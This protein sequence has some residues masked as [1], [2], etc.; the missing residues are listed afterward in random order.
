MAYA[1]FYV[2]Q[3]QFWPGL[4]LNGEVLPGNPPLPAQTVSAG[5]EQ[6][7]FGGLATVLPAI[8][9]GAPITIIAVVERRDPTGLTFVKDSGI[10]T[11]KDI[12]GKTVGAFPGSQNPALIRVAMKRSGI[13]ESKVRFVNVTAGGE[14]AMLRLKTIDAQAGYAGSQNVRLQCDGTEAGAIAVSDFGVDLYG[15]AIIANTNWMRDVGD[16]VVSRAL[17]GIVKAATLTKSDP[18]QAVA[19]LSKLNPQQP[20]DRISELATISSI[21]FVRF[22]WDNNSEILKQK[23]F[24]WVDADELDK[25]QNLL[26][27]AGI[28]QAKADPAK[29]YTTHFLEDPRVKAA[30][31]EW[32]NTPW[33]QMPADVQEKCNVH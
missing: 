28:I 16:E 3:D 19:I 24:G 1:T 21:G 5:S 11:L 6:I 32:S 13:D 22:S 9:Q 26:V 27:E 23:G 18:S 14:V 4:N 8:S 33:A 17:L 7:G 29:A 25:T 31:L 2:A 10:R 15:Q 12:E 20:I 30:A